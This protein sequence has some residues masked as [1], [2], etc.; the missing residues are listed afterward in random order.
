MKATDEL[1]VE[2]LSLPSG[3]RASLTRRLLDSLESNAAS[4]EV[5]AAWKTEVLD[6]CRASDAGELPDR[7]AAEVLTEVRE[8]RR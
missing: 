1:F 8:H 2:A 7:P 4:P 3:L 6:R 5:E